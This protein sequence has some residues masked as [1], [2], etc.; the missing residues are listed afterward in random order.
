[1]ADNQNLA[2]SQYSAT[3]LK[4]VKTDVSPSGEA[5]QLVRPMLSKPEKT[6]EDI[7]GALVN[8]Y[9]YKSKELVK[10]SQ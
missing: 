7:V 3:S 6:T 8:Q 10:A 4:V 2:Q 9:D 1:M 5:I